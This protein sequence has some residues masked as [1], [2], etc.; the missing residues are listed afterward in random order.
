MANCHLCKKCISAE[1]LE[2]AKKD[3]YFYNYYNYKLY[4]PDTLVC[5]QCHNLWYWGK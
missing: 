2:Q 4:N 3:G 5:L 1:K